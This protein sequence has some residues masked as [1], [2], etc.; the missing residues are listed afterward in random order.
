MHRVRIQSLAVVAGGLVGGC[1]SPA[2]TVDAELG[3]RSSLVA[4]VPAP[5]GGDDT[6]ALQA[7]LEQCAPGGDGCVVQLGAGAYFTKQLYVR[8]FH[9]AI[10]G[11]GMDATVIEA[12]TPYDVGGP[13][14]DPYDGTEPDPLLNPQP[15]VINLF[16]SSDVTMADLTLR[17]SDPVPVPEGFFYGDTVHFLKAE[18]AVT[19]SGRFYRVGFRGTSDPAAPVPINVDNGPQIIGSGPGD[20]IDIRACTFSGMGNGYEIASMSRATITIGGSPAGGNSFEAGS[21]A[22]VFLGVDAS[23]VE[24][25]HNRSVE[26]YA[27]NYWAILLIQNTRGYSYTAPSTFIIDHNK[28]SGYGYGMNGIFVLDRRGIL[29]TP[30]TVDLVMTDNVVDIHEPEGGWSI[31]TMGLEDPLVARNRVTGEAAMGIVVSNTRRS[32]GLLQANNVAGLASELPIVLAPDWLIGA[33]A[34][35]VTVVGGDVRANVYDFGVDDVLVGVNNAGAGVGLA[36]S[37]AMRRKAALVH[38]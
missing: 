5:S 21:N 30:R 10:R 29:D 15:H 28:F 35:G 32:G 1:G 8:D 14:H 26:S 24:I 36:V 19:G 31:V 33:P 20:M 34:M 17:V 4:S 11:A 12:L 25:S 27:G 22:G 38:D 7:A 9:G 3:L 18:V 2:P 23:R 6:Q 37:E 13:A 16:G